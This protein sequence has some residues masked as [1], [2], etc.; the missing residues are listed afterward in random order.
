LTQTN[1]RVIITTSTNK[2]ERKKMT[3]IEILRAS[4]V[5]KENI[6]NAR[7][8]Q[9]FASVK[10]ANGQPLN[11]K[12]GG[13]KTLAAWG[14]QEDAIRNAQDEV[15]K[16]KDAIEREESKV[17]LVKITNRTLP[18]A[19]IVKVESGELVQ[20]RKHPNTFFVSGV[21][22]ARIVWLEKKKAL[23]HRYLSEV[24]DR[25]QFTKFA[26]AYNGINKE[27]NVNI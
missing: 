17:L 10:S 1:K 7:F 18:E 14:K 2:I 3:R 26:K 22:K 5:K 25:E 13:H 15:Q 20:W 11:D 23:A 9:Y 24:T 12:R 21:D 8:N 4:L 19:I 27:I 6:L 16:T